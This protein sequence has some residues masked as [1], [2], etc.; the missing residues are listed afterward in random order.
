MG[1][2]HSKSC[3]LL[4]TM[5]TKIWLEAVLNNSFS[6]VFH[7]LYDTLTLNQAPFLN[8]FLFMPININVII[9]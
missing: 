2:Y 9:S 5:V 7:S 3:L 6:I 4:V 8:L 1:I